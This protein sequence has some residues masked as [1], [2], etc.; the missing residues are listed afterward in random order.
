[1]IARKTTKGQALDWMCYVCG[2]PKHRGVERVPM[3]NPCM[4]FSRNR[5]GRRKVKF[6]QDFEAKVAEVAVAQ[7]FQGKGY[8]WIRARA[9]R[10]PADLLI[11]HPKRKTGYAIQVK[12]SRKHMGPRVST[13]DRERLQEAAWRWGFQAAIAQVHINSLEIKLEITDLNG[14]AILK[15]TVL[16]RAAWKYEICLTDAEA[17]KYLRKVEKR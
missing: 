17:Q 9:S 5:H 10:G 15:R 4:D 3:C 7:Y 11:W 14:E 6:M 8:R 12:S 2:T 13:I 16:P 1:M